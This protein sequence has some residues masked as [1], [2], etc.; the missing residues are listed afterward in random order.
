MLY[1]WMNQF[2]NIFVL[3]CSICLL[4]KYYVWYLL[5]SVTKWAYSFFLLII[6]CLV[7][8]W[9]TLRS[10]FRYFWNNFWYTLALIVLTNKVVSSKLHAYWKICYYSMRVLLWMVWTSLLCLTNLNAL[11]SSMLKKTPNN[12]ITLRRCNID[13]TSG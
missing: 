6:L 12:G 5:Y 1:S 4:L 9:F 3:L 10:W 8:P 13:T 11:S 7:L 2:I